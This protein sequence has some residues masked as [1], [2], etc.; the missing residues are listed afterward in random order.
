VRGVKLGASG[1][2]PRSVCSRRP[3]TMELA[4]AA[5]CKREWPTCSG[6]AASSEASASYEELS[7]IWSRRLHPSE[8]SSPPSGST[9]DAG[10][11][12]VVDA[13]EQRIVVI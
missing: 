4:L 5:T 12:T 6:P 7:E 10:T 8:S 9:A 2:G 13:V 3:D 11:C 1:V